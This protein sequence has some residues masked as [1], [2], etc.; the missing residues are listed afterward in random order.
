MNVKN[1]HKS[2]LLMTPQTGAILKITIVLQVRR[3]SKCVIQ[4]DYRRK[5]FVR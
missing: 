1:G 4:N 2:W 3:G 5:R